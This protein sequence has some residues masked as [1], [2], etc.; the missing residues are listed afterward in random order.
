MSP[1]V[2]QAMKKQLKAFRKKFHRDP[3]P[4]DPIFFDPDADTPQ[5]FSEAKASE[6]FDEMMNVA[7]EAN[8]RPALIYAMKKTGRIVTEQNRK[9]LSPEEL[10]EW[11]AA[12]DEYKSMQ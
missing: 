8:I 2:A 3:G 4:G 11:D 12:I 1:E 10:A 9:L 6:I 5:P 7:K